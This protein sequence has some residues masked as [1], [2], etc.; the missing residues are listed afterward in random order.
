MPTRFHTKAWCAS[1]GAIAALLVGLLTGLLAGLCSAP[2]LAQDEAYATLTRAAFFVAEPDATITFYKDVLGYEEGKTARNVGPYD[3]D[4]AW[5]I[6]A[7]SHL[8]LTYLKSR[9]GAY[10]AVM[11]LEDARLDTL[12]RPGGTANAFGD[13]MLI[14]LVQN[15][16]EVY[17]RALAGGYEVIKP[18]TLSGSGTSKQMFLRDPNGI[19]VELNEIL[20]AAPGSN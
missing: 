13:V 20:S 8:R 5:G 12:P 6:P 4:N 11:G 14:H 3:A 17:A 19:R 1:I 18:P 2:S 10:V 9:E 15:M 16:D 7:G